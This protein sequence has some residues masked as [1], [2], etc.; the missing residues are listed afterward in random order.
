MIIEEQPQIL[1]STSVNNLYHQCTSIDKIF[2]DA[3]LCRIIIYLTKSS[4]YR[5]LP[6]LSKYFNNLMKTEPDLYS[7]YI[8][9]IPYMV[10]TTKT[11]KLYGK[12]IHETNTIKIYNKLQLFHLKK[13][14]NMNFENDNI[15]YLNVVDIDD[16]RTIASHDRVNENSG[17]TSPLINDTTYDINSLSLEFEINDI[18]DLND[19][20]P[21][22]IWSSIPKW[23]FI[24][25]NIN[26]QYNMNKNGLKSNEIL[27][28]I[29]EKASSSIKSII[30]NKSNKNILINQKDII[31]FATFD[32]LCYL[33]AC[34]DFILTFLSYSNECNYI[35]SNLLVIDFINI[36]ENMINIINNN[37]KQ[38]LILRLQ[39]Q[40]KNDDQT[41]SYSIIL[42]KT[43]EFIQINGFDFNSTTYT[44]D[45]TN[46]TNLISVMFKESCLIRQEL[47]DNIVCKAIQERIIWN[48][49][50]LIQC[51]I[52]DEVDREYNSCWYRYFAS[53]N[54]SSFENSFFS[55]STNIPKIQYIRYIDDKNLS[56]V[57]NKY[58]QNI[59]NKQEQYQ[60]Q[61]RTSRPIT[62]SPMLKYNNS[63][64][65]H[66]DEKDDLIPHFIDDSLYHN[67]LENVNLLNIKKINQSFNHPLYTIL[68]ND[69]N[70][71]LLWRLLLINKYKNNS[72]L[73]QLKL[74][75]YSKLINMN[76]IKWVKSLG[77]K[78]PYLPF[79][80]FSIPNRY[81]QD[82][83]L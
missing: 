77:Y 51:F 78:K 43:L 79:V 10:Y 48:E 21:L 39:F 69:K 55:I 18:E 6:I 1:Q 9:D 64:S 11:S 59:V 58:K 8:I 2:N 38:L 61:H 60:I 24:L 20:I 3:I 7:Q 45:F 80:N 29:L 68:S 65:I 42:P 12:I 23:N 44:L 34:N 82:S 63:L 66:D 14:P 62:A 30:I 17:D 37:L 26:G 81:S 15:H 35:L 50:E 33:Q 47:F 36:E 41:Q 53:F 46:C 70:D 52:I 74:E 75:Q 4:M 73:L 71:G 76:I 56:V 22:K 27:N 54:M 16:N 5:K 57:A 40:D 32:Q 13:T 83:Q 67:P 31:Y 49:T 19:N 25:N 72:K 28:K